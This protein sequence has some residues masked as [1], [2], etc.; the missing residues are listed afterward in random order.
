M[1]TTTTTTEPPDA[2]GNNSQ[3]TEADI[4]GQLAG[5]SVEQMLAGESANPDAGN[6]APAPDNAS[7]EASETPAQ[8]TQAGD[9]NQPQQGQ[10]K[11]REEKSEERAAKTWE[12]INR[13]KAE[14]QKQ[15]EELARQQ[16]A[17]RRQRQELLP[18]AKKA[19]QSAEDYD[20]MAQEWAAEGRDDLAQRAKERAA[21]LRREAQ[22]AQAQGQAAALQNAQMAVMRDVVTANPELKDK[23]SELFRG[24][25]ELMRAKPILATYPEGIRDAVDVVRSRLEARTAASLR[26]EVETLKKQLAERE[27]LLQPGTGAPSAGTSDG[28]PLEELSGPEREK[29]ILAEL[30]AADSRGVD[31]WGG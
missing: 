4:L 31:P 13:E 7:A 23:G 30:R 16:E 22:E 17:I 12:E 8:S 27:K 9:G 26:A 3:T 1:D 29:R 19:M 5:L 14:L 21:S 25:E 10:P 20:R 6:R 24:V 11:P 28:K 18:E 15:R 2:T